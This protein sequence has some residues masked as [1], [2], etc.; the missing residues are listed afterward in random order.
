MSDVWL[1]IHEQLDEPSEVLSVHAT[2]A[3]AEAAIREASKRPVTPPWPG[4]EPAHRLI[5]SRDGGALMID[6]EGYTEGWKVQRFELE[7]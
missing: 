7:A 1:A 3:G 6:V 2:P 5:E 4:A